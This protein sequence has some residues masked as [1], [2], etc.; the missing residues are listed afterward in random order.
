MPTTL[1]LRA[2]IL[3]PSSDITALKFRDWL[4]SE[5]ENVDQRARLSGQPHYASI[6][7]LYMPEKLHMAVGQVKLTKMLRGMINRY[8]NIYR[9]ELRRTQQSLTPQEVELASDELREYLESLKPTNDFSC[10]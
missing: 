5:I 8:E 9:I 4:R 1:H 2:S 7:W 10:D 6:I 3:N